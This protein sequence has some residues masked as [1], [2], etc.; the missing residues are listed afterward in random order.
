MVNFGTSIVPIIVAFI[1]VTM[2]PFFTV[3]ISSLT[4]HN[5]I[6]NVL[7]APNFNN[8]GRKAVITLTNNGSAP[9]SNLSLAIIAPKKITQIINNFSAASISLPQL[10]N[11]N[12]KLSLGAP[13][14]IDPPTSFIQIH[15]PKLVQGEGSLT[16]LQI[17]NNGN[18]HSHY[19]NYT[20]VAIYDQGSSLA[21]LMPST[22]PSQIEVFLYNFIRPPF[23]Y[24]LIIYPISYGVI[25]FW[26][27]KWY[28]RRRR[29][30]FMAQM[31]DE[32]ISIHHDLNENPM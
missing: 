26:Y 10:S 27:S 1:T 30:K 12:N 18:P 19:Y 9:A 23:I 6:V 17:L 16:K 2:S 29:R 11:C 8:D 15:I 14:S 4:S 20:G 3:A 32:I 28:M 5:P 22:K 25:Y 24:F 31:R 21:R 13:K 7:I